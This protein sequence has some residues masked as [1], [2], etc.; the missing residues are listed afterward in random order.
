MSNKKAQ[1]GNIIATLPILFLLVIIVAAFILISVALA[2]AYG[3]NSQEAS[4]PQI[5]NNEIYFKEITLQNSEGKQITITLFD[6][7]SLMLRQPI[8]VRQEK[9]KETLPTLLDYSHNCLYFKIGAQSPEAYFNEKKLRLEEIG[10]FANK[11][12]TI[13][14]KNLEITYFYGWCENE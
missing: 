2:K 3:T 10:I 6:A 5:K 12:N 11:L 14:I 9:I 4:I 8:V 1:L 13:K 7:L